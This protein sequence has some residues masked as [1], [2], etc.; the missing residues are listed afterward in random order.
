MNKSKVLLIMSREIV[1]DSII[2]QAK[3]NASF[4][5]LAEHDY[6]AAV[7]KAIEYRPKIVIV[8][9]PESG[10]YRNAENCLR[11][12]DRIRKNLP[13]AK[14]LLLCSETDTASGRVAIQAKLENRIDDFLFYDTSVNYLF[15]KLESLI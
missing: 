6:S 13:H 1:A 8:E 10:S 14:Q 2:A 11:I 5:F 7:R 15:S 4:E 3:A 9:V 12:S